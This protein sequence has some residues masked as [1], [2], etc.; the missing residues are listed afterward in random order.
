MNWLKSTDNLQPGAYYW[1]LREGEP[2]EVMKITNH[3]GTLWANSAF[4]VGK[5]CDGE[6]L[7]VASLLAHHADLERRLAAIEA[8]TFHTQIIGP[9]HERIEQYGADPEQ[10]QEL[11]AEFLNQPASKPERF[12]I[13]DG[14]TKPA[15]SSDTP[16]I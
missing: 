12:D 13:L 5:H 6:W 7:P 3:H 2:I 8:R 14:V 10:L 16:V 11:A 15:R 9:G 4:I 1:R